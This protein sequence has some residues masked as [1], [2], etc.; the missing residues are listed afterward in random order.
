MVISRF[1][2][3]RVEG[4]GENSGAVSNRANYLASCRGLAAIAGLALGLGLISCIAAAQPL[5][6]PLAG[7]GPIDPS[8][9]VQPSPSSLAYQRWK[10]FRDRHV[11][12]SGRM[13]R[14][15]YQRALEDY[16]QKWGSTLSRSMAGITGNTWVPIGPDHIAGNP[17]R[18]GRVT[19]IA[20]HPTDPNTI[21]VGTAAGGVWRTTDG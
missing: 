2:F 21:Y 16:E 12:S 14:G 4:I 10:Y 13:P 15:A 9:A 1:R 7:P 11:D 18:S 3:H 19:S 17:T 20:V 5:S 8:L 6:N